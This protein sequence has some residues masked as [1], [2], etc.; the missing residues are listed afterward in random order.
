[1]TRHRKTR[2]RKLLSARI[3]GGTGRS[4]KC[5]YLAFEFHAQGVLKRILKDGNNHF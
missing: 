4:L 2:K 3:M 1:M 5:G